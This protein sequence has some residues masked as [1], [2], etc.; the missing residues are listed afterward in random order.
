MIPQIDIDTELRRLERLLPRL[1]AELPPEEVLQAFATEA[2][3]L[4]HVAAVDDVTRIRTRIG[5]MLATAGL[6]PGS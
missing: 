1:V 2:D 5:R 3:S 6:I 4:S